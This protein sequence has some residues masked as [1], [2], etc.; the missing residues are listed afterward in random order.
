MFAVVDHV[1]RILSTEAAE[2]VD[3]RKSKEKQA[4]KKPLA[5]P[6]ENSTER[7]AL[8]GTISTFLQ[9]IFNLLL[10]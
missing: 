5:D 7:V 10:Q 3:L 2:E 8:D 6:G 9:F 4:P 1:E